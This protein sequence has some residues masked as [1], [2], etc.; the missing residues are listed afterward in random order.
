MAGLAI[1]VALVSSVARTAD[2]PSHVGRPISQWAQE[3][4]SPEPSVRVKAA[5]VLQSVAFDYIIRPTAPGSAEQ[6]ATVAALKSALPQLLKA[7]RDESLQVQL[8]VIST[9]ATLADASAAPTLLELA[10]HANER[11]RGEAAVAVH[12]IQV[13]TKDPKLAAALV[14]I[15]CETLKTEALQAVSAVLP[16]GPGSEGA[17]PCLI[18]T[19]ETGDPESQRLAAITLGFMQPPPMQAVAAL[20]KA[21]KSTSKDVREAASEALTRIRG[22]KK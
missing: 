20:T 9:L 15:F 13:A 3:L 11:V 22:A 8:S 1:A 10:T 7:A 18:A 2:E 17:V 14:P 4:S 16:E 19:L 12:A 21:A 6:K 5:Q